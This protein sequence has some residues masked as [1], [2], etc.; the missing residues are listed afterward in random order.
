MWCKVEVLLAEKKLFFVGWLCMSQK[1]RSFSQPKHCL[2]EQAI[3][4]S[5]NAANFRNRHRKFAPSHNLLFAK[6]TV[7][8][9]MYALTPY[10][11]TPERRTDSKPFRRRFVRKTGFDT[12]RRKFLQNHF[13]QSFE[14]LPG[15]QRFANLWR[16]FWFFLH[17]AKRIKPFPLQGASRFCKPRIN[18][19][20]QQL[21]TNKIKSF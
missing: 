4:L 8:L 15:V 7:Y 14:S 1:S 13:R 9:S 3:L 10:A 21:R 18:S 16:A 2:F 20:R 5:S 12:C 6:N 11:V 17:D 19:Q